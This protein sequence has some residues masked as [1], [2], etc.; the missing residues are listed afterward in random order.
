MSNSFD[1]KILLENK[2]SLNSCAYSTQYLHKNVLNQSYIKEFVDYL[3][4][5]LA[6]KSLHS[7]KENKDAF[8]NY[9]DKYLAR[10]FYYNVLETLEYG[11]RSSPILPPI[12]YCPTIFYQAH[13]KFI[14]VV[15]NYVNFNF[16]KTIGYE[17]SIN[18]NLKLVD[19]VLNH[20]FEFITKDYYNYPCF[21]EKKNFE[22]N[23][24]LIIKNNLGFEK[25]LFFYLITSFCLVVLIFIMLKIY[26][27]KLKKTVLSNFKT[28]L[29]S[30]NNNNSKNEVRNS[31]FDM[32]KEGIRVIENPLEMNDYCNQYLKEQNSTVCL[33]CKDNVSDD[34]NYSSINVNVV[35]ESIPILNSLADDSLSFETNRLSNTEREKCIN[36][37]DNKVKKQVLNNL[38]KRIHVYASVNKIL[39]EKKQEN[40]F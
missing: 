28:I 38:D 25:N 27:D 1:D 32:E 24:E 20:G 14:V 10:F 13:Y 17:E 5:F 35:A 26:F 36:I 8:L 18:D 29:V 11:F 12:L 16:N 4:N 2:T 19:T 30:N 7:M 6:K 34:I 9:T 23:E 15:L 33:K 31:A 39:K 21:I 22:Y 40:D 37:S 3:L